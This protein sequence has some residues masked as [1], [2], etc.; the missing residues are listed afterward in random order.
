M[1]LGEVGDD[2]DQMTEVADETVELPHH[3]R[4]TFTQRF[5]ACVQAWPVILLSGR[6]VAVHIF[7]IDAGERESV[8]LQVEHLRAIGFRDA[9]VAD[10]G[11]GLRL[12]TQT[13]V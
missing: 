13:F 11:R 9:H 6:L 7:L 2:V 5:E 3:E 4:V 1:T 10:Q 12:V 8:L